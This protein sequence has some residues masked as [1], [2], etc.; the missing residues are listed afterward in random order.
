MKLG[1]AAV[2]LAACDESGGWSGAP[3][4]TDA[5]VPI[6]PAIT[7]SLGPDGGE[8]AS[9]DGAFRLVVPAG[10]LSAE[11]ELTL[12]PITNTAWGG[13]GDA[14]RLSPE[15]A[16]DAP[17]QLVFAYD[18]ADLLGTTEDAL[19]VATHDA[20]G[21]WRAFP[22]GAVDAEA[23]TLTV[24]TEDLAGPE[25]LAH[26]AEGAAD[27]ARHWRF[28]LEP[29]EATVK[30][31][32]RKQLALKACTYTENF[33]WPFFSEEDG[34]GPPQPY[35]HSADVTWKVTGAY[36][37]TVSGDR[38][39]GTYTAPRARAAAGSLNFVT[40]AFEIGTRRFVPK[41]TIHIDAEPRTWVGD[42][43]LSTGI[44]TFVH[45]LAWTLDH[46]NGTEEWYV[47]SGRV[48]L[49]VTAEECTFAPLE[50]EVVPTDGLLVIDTAADPP[51]YAGYGTVGWTVHQTCDGHTVDLPTVASFFGKADG[52]V[53]PIGTIRLDGDLEIIEHSYDLGGGAKLSWRFIGE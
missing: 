26:G 52:G 1:I 48:R 38:S 25:P 41:T 34:L 3:E 2:V 20:E 36:E 24:E 43:T 30:R 16:F 33:G 8:L 51:T 28:R 37:G 22:D 27:F 9:E 47:P 5:G 40:A 19:G 31:G 42:S 10:A 29:V 53:G 6:G 11:T 45:D 13:L 12:E 49:T 50:H 35:T 39:R 32:G 4:P 7:A 44:F 15:V 17:V 18:D 21:Y 14:W 46:V 23:R